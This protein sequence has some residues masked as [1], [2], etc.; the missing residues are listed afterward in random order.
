MSDIYQR[1]LKITSNHYPS[2]YKILTKNKSVTKFIVAGSSAAAVDLIFLAIFHD[3]FNWSIVLSTSLAFIL[4]FAVSFHLQ[5]FW[6]FRNKDK[7]KIPK[8]LTIYMINA[9][10]TLNLN[11][12]FM[13]LL[14]DRLGVWYL[15][16]QVI[17]NVTIGV[18]NFFVYKYVVFKDKH[19][20]NS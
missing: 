15:L 13:H 7:K 10:L 12:L 9:L 19:E 14:V 2:V 18:Y 20:T 6:T 16:S 17:V 4:A 5:K 1:L 8:Q 3:L 11:G